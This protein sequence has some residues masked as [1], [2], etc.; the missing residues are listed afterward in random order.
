M[1]SI[2]LLGLACFHESPAPPA[3]E[4]PT[5]QAPAVQAPAAVSIHR[6]RGAVLRDGGALAFRPCG[7]E[8]LV[9]IQGAAL[10]DLEEVYTSLAEEDAGAVVG[11]ELTGALG[12]LGE[13]RVL[14]VAAVAMA[15]PPG[16]EGL[17]AYDSSFSYRARGQE[18]FWAMTV[19]EEQLT[20]SSP[21]LD[22]PMQVRVIPTRQPG[23]AIS[24]SGALEGH[25]VDLSLQPTR[26]RDDMSGAVFPFIATALV[27]GGSLHGCGEQGWVGGMR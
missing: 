20:Y 6:M 16:Q 3:Q 23:G 14:D 19:A 15:L 26:C 8:G 9:G 17:C 18:P 1:V 12:E 2:L 24:F 27:D 5:V 22:S 7:E 21:D 25:H 4:A 10:S 13:Q 11:V